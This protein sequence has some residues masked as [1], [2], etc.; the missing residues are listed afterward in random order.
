MYEIYEKLLTSAK[1]VNFSLI[2]THITQSSPKI[3]KYYLG[4][5]KLY[6]CFPNRPLNSPIISRS[7]SLYS[8]SDANVSIFTK[9]DYE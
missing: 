8:Y 3:Q 1:T 6:L 7:N 4:S 5:L 9:T 2:C